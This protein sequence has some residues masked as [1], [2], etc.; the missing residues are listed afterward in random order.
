ML[1]LLNRCLL[2]HSRNEVLKPIIRRLLLNNSADILVLL[3]L[4]LLLH[5]RSELLKPIGAQLEL[6]RSIAWLD[7]V[8]AV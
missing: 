4:R 5:S 7:W 3:H 6:P 8:S 1:E 2:L